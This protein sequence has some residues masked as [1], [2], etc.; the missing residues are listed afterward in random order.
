V[1]RLSTVLL[2]L[3]ALLGPV[4]TVE[5]QIFSWRDANGTLVLSDKPPA[6]AAAPITTY[7][8]PKTSETVRVTRPAAIGYGD[9]YD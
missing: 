5:A 1:Y 6:D 4:A 7:Q 2:V 3:A 8:V 9:R